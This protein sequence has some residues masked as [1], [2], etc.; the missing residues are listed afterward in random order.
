MNVGESVVVYVGAVAS[1]W[2]MVRFVIEWR[3][4]KYTRAVAT[5]TA[6]LQVEAA[7]VKSIEA[8]LE[9]LLRLQAEET[10]S[11]ERTIS[12]LR[13]RLDELDEQRVADGLWKRAALEYISLLRKTWNAHLPDHPAPPIPA[14]LD[15][16]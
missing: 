16:D 10:A 9:L 14:V 3:A 13:R 15:I 5:K 2:A 6:P 11:R 12:D 4:G 1:L 7:T 8:R